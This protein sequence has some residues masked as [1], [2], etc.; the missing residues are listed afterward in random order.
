MRRL[1]PCRLA[2]KAKALF[3][4]SH[5]HCPERKEKHGQ[6]I[7]SELISLFAFNFL[8]FLE[9]AAHLSSQY[10]RMHCKLSSIVTPKPKLSIAPRQ[11]SLNE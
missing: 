8:A 1:A 10:V 2:S 5:K 3:S 9:A 11:H 7:D 6:A 4:T